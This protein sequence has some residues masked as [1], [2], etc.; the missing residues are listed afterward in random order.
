MQIISEQES[1]RGQ[2]LLTPNV[3]RQLIRSYGSGVQG[4]F[5]EYIDHSVSTFQ[6]QQE[7]LQGVVRNMMEHSPLAIMGKL[8]DTNLEAWRSISTAF[9]RG[10]KDKDK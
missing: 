9:T 8:M 4:L 6:E 7:T 2:S 10:E 5:R 3:L 1:Q